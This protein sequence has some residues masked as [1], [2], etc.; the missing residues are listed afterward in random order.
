LYTQSKIKHVLISFE[1]YYIIK[2]CLRVNLVTWLYLLII[3]LRLLDC[4]CI[5]GFINLFGSILLLRAILSFLLWP[6]F[7][8]FRM[9]LVTNRILSSVFRLIIMFVSWHWTIIAIASKINILNFLL[10]IMFLRLNCLWSIQICIRRVVIIVI[11][12]IITRIIII[13]WTNR[14]LQLFSNCNM[15]V[16]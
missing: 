11:S 5:E 10:C 2:L 6:F 12:I 9:S 16:E 13:C 15:I 8:T 14:V 7:Y 3:V 1:K 4:N